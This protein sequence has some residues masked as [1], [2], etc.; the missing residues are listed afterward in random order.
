[1]L[2]YLVHFT[3][4]TSNLILYNTVTLL[5]RLILARAILKGSSIIILDEATSAVDAKTDQLIQK[6]LKEIKNKDKKI[7]I[8]FISHRLSSLLFANHIIEIDNGKIKFEGTLNSFRRK[9]SEIN[10]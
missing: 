8:I 5:Q 2:L 1:M 6:S 4:H 7:T 10:I 3:D 9:S